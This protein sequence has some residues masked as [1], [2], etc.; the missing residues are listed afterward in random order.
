[1]A[2][3]HD[4][5]VT[6]QDARMRAL[7][8]LLDRAAITRVIQNWGLARDTGRWDELRAAYT[9]DATM[10]TTWFS[11][12]AAEFVERSMSSAKG[13]ARSQH[14]MGASSIDLNGDRAIAETRFVLL[15]RTSAHSVEVDATCYARFYD[16]FVRQGGEWRIQK[17]VPVYEKSRIDPVEPGAALKLDADELARYPEGYRYVAYL[18]AKAGTSIVPGLPTPGS[19]ALTRLYADGRAWLAGT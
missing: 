17:R 2:D 18:Q 4:N 11:G 5:A 12:S 19:E 16:R 3:A 1:M 8:E 6:R 9:S 14:F 13:K 7:D 15:L 10:H